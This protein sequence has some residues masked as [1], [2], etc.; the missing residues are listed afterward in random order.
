[1]GAA[2]PARLLALAALAACGQGKRDE[3]APA[4]VAPA[5][6]TSAHAAGREV[7]ARVDGEPIYADCVTTQAAAHGLDRAAALA[8]CVDFELLAQEARRRGLATDADVLAARR[9]EMVRALV[10]AD[11]APTLD[12]PSDVP[13]ADVRWLWETQLERRYNRPERRRATYCRV[14]V[15]KVAAAGGPEDRAARALSGSLHDALGSMRD[16]DA[17]RFAALCWM[18]AGGRVVSTTARQ[19]NPFLR[20]GRHEGGSYA[21]AFADAAFSISEVGQISAPTRTSWGWDVVLLTELLPAE[22]KTLAEAEPE[23]RDG[24]VHRVETEPYRRK[25]FEAWI[26]GVLAGHAIQLFPDNIPDE[27]ALASSEGAR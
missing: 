27:R 3:P 19:T 25:R 10:E 23:I 13:E 17:A 16:H 5:V 24:L 6:A 2:R 11:Y 12:D 21:Q 8:E 26:Q 7:V 14:P 18:A 9:T 1:M 4:R 20:S 22:A 15:D